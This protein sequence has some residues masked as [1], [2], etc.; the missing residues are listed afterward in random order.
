MRAAADRAV[1]NG[2][3]NQPYHV[4]ADHI[5]F[6]TVDRFL[7]ASDFYTID[8]ADWI[9]KPADKDLITEFVKRH[10]ELVGELQIPDL[11]NLPA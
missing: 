4:D 11:A 3:W 7:E 8:V 2:G 9:G 1:R 5:N 10:A 6:D